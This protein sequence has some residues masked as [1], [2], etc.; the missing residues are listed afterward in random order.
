MMKAG[1]VRA[2]AV[3]SNT[4]LPQHADVPTLTE[5]GFPGMRAAQW[6]AAFAHSSVPP[7]IIETLHKAFAQAMT[8]P[9]LQEAFV[10]GGMLAP[11][12]ASLDETRAW[13][14]DEMASWKRDIGDVGIVVEE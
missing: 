2:L 1:R 3:A 8:A 7:E 14:K 6:V 4:R 11:K 13:I 9:A 10:R 5:V 12:H